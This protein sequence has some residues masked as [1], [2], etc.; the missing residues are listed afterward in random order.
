MKKDYFVIA[1]FCCFLFAV[2]CKQSRNDV[3][4]EIL[5][6]RYPNDTITIDGL[7]WGKEAREQIV[8]IDFWSPELDI[9]NEHL[10]L[11]LDSIKNGLI[12]DV[13]GAIYSFIN[14]DR[15]REYFDIHR[16]W[17]YQESGFHWCCRPKI[18][19]F[20]YLFGF[21][22]NHHPG[23]PFQDAVVVFPN[24]SSKVEV[25][26]PSILDDDY[27]IFYVGHNETPD[28]IGLYRNI[29]EALIILNKENS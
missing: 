16:C 20:G 21:C 9:D 4:L 15:I 7:D 17:T 22:K 11:L 24:D 27:S 29:Q 13:S 10:T 25:Y 1:F 8:N 18:N 23:K 5:Q 12:N 26:S 19:A 28:F 14:Q 3:V 2:G 6:K